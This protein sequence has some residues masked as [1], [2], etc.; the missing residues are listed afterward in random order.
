[1][2]GFFMHDGKLLPGS[3]AI[4]GPESRGLRFGDGLFETIRHTGLDMPLFPLHMD[5]FFTG[6][7]RLGFEA[8]A[9]TGRDRIHGMITELL[10]KNRIEGAARIRLM[11]YRS[12]G[13]VHDPVSDRPHLVIQCWPLPENY[14]RLNE[15]GLVLGVYDGAVKAPDGLSSLK[16]NNF[17]PY[18]MAARHAREMHWNDALLLS[19]VGHV[20]DSTIANI[21]WLTG[22]GL[23]TP[24]LSDG[25]VAGC[26]RRHLMETLEDAG[27]PVRERSVTPE[28]LRRADEVFLTNAMYGIRSVGRFGDRIYARPVTESLYRDHVRPLYGI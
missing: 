11:A 2:P 14:S 7:E 24:P 9:H 3:D 28:A 5:R 10:R 18:L 4:A 13:G 16:H 15:N 22:E 27:F 21:F 26:F 1:M 20:A 25:P 19:P 23:F 17:L 6:L 12:D 8:P